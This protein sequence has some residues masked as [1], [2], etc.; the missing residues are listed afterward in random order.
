MVKNKILKK[1]TTAISFF[2]T[3]FRD[4]LKGQVTSAWVMEHFSNYHAGYVQLV[5]FRR[6]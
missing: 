1:D 4:W 6:A 2:E 3:L 5:S